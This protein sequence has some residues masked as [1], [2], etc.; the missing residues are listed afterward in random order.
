MLAGA[1]GR[2]RH[3]I[4]RSLRFNSGDSAHLT[5][6]PSSAGN[7]T[8]FTWSAWVKTVRSDSHETLFSATPAG[9]GTLQYDFILENDQLIVYGIDTFFVYQKKLSRAF[10]DRSA[11]YHLVV[12]FDTTDSTAEDRIK[13]YVNGE[14]ETDFATNQNPSASR[15]TGFNKTEEHSI[16]ARTGYSGAQY[17]D[18]YQTEINFIDGLQLGPEYFGETDLETGAWIPKKYRGSFGT[19]GFYLNFADNSG[20][21]AT[22][23]GKDSS[24]N[25]NN[26]TPNN[27]SVTA[28]AGNDSLLDTPTN[29]W[30]T[31]N[32][33][34]TDNVSTFSNGNLET[35][36]NNA[37]TSGGSIAVN[38]GK[39]YAEVVCT[40]KTAVNAMVGIC[41]IRGFDGERQVDESQRGGSGHG[42]VMNATKLSGGASYGATWAVNDVIGIALD[43][44]SAQNTVTFYK[45]GTSQGAINIDNAEYVFACSNGQASSTVTYAY[46]F[47]QRAFVYTPPAGYA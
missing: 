16:G 7:S 46:N 35:V 14:R 33:L 47:G 24:G 13:I 29:N 17:F 32:P 41:T 9:N 6:T 22:T 3:E 45:N 28:G 1:A 26:W 42:Y 30:C 43:L 12:A 23:L 20:V 37:S 2:S 4:E 8:T 38:S 40:A 19:N 15:T 34:N 5:R 36:C 21:T 27:F 11:W 10:R 39:W 44:D 31:L 25:G 18:G